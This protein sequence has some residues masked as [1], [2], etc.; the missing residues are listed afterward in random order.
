[1]TS[2]NLYNNLKDCGKN[3]GREKLTYYIHFESGGIFLGIIKSLLADD[4]ENLRAH[5]TRSCMR[6]VRKL[7][8]Q[9]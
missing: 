5:S 4:K 9:L 3:R 6:E 8:F 7:K 2:D 1:M